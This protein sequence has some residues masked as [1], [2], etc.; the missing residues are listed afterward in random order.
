MVK[1]LGQGSSILCTDESLVAD[2]D[3]FQEMVK[4]IQSLSLDSPAKRPFINSN[5][6]N[7]SQASAPGGNR[8]LRTAS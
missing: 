2:N 7:A 4:G 6:E 5:T 1:L 8:G 3:S